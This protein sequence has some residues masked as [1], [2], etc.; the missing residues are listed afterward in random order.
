MT[1]NPKPVDAI[2]KWIKEQRA[3]WAWRLAELD[4]ILARESP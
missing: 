4:R 3:L 1:L 2:A